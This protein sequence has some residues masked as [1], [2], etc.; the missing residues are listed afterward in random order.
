L[1]ADFPEAARRRLAPMILPANSR[2]RRIEIQIRN[3]LSR[4][5][6]NVCLAHEYHQKTIQ[7]LEFGEIQK[8]GTEGFVW[9][10]LRVPV[11]NN[12]AS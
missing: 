7:S 8:R 6:P 5:I 2:H 3:H 4:H 11:L 10:V 1:P 12:C 9:G